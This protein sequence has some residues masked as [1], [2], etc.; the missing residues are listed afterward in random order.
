MP[1]RTK[2]AKFFQLQKHLKSIT[3]LGRDGVTQNVTVALIL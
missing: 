3:N 1:D 2:N